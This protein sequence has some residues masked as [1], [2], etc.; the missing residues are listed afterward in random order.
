MVE[1]IEVLLGVEALGDSRNIV[2]LLDGSHD[3]HMDS[4]RLLPNYFGHRIAG[5]CWHR[6]T[7]DFDSVSL[8]PASCNRI[9][10]V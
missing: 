5:H 1:R 4:I 6:L 3:F 10:I 2:G 7:K 8:L 9:V